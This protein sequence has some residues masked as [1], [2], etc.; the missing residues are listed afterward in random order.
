M[1][2]RDLDKSAI[3]AVFVVLITTSL[4]KIAGGLFPN[5]IVLFGFWSALT[6]VFYTISHKQIRWQQTLFVS[7]I[8]QPIIHGSSHSLHSSSLQCAPSSHHHL[9]V[10]I[11]P[12]SSVISANAQSDNSSISMILAHLFA[13]MF[14]QISTKLNIQA[15]QMA[16]LNSKNSWFLR[17]DLNLTPIKIDIKIVKNFLENIKYYVD[18]VFQDTLIRRGPPV[19]INS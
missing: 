13:I 11:N 9:I 12:C 5:L 4:H 15:I 3:N 16:T 18:S 19:P 2:K 7:M 10:A 6:A 14:I 1:G 8:S 17:F